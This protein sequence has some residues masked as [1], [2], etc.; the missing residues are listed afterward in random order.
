MGI[1]NKYDKLNHIETNPRNIKIDFDEFP[2]VQIKVKEIYNCEI[3]GT[4]SKGKGNFHGNIVMSSLVKF[5]ADEADLNKVDWKDSNLRKCS[6][7][8]TSFDLGAV[9]NCNFSECSFTE[10]HFDNMSITGAT[11]YDTEFVNC[12][13]T[14]MVIESCQF[15][16]CS[17]KNCKTSN[18]VFEHCLL[19]DCIFVNTDIQ[20]QTILENFG[21]E[22]GQLNNCNV[23]SASTDEN[24]EFLSYHAILS[25]CDKD[26]SIHNFFK[27]KLEYFLNPK[28]TLNG[29]ILF[30]NI[31]RIGEW[32]PLCKV[33]TTFINMFKLF[34]DF[35]I[36]LFENNRTPIFTIYKLKEL[37]GWLSS[38]ELIKNNFELYP[39]IIGFDLGL[40][41]IISQTL[42]IIKEKSETLEGKISLLVEGPL[43][44]NFYYSILTKG[45]KGNFQITKLI[46]QNSPNILEIT[47]IS[48]VIIQFVALFVVTR[49]KAEFSKQKGKKKTKKKDITKSHKKPA[50]P[51][52][53]IKFGDKHNED[54]ILQLY[55]S[56][57]LNYQVNY[58]E[59]ISEDIGK[60][61]KVIID[62]Y[63][64]VS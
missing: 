35:F 40:S 37:T 1:I 6:F 51:Y 63:D 4:F 12:D 2:K 28:I 60:I 59:F 5:R 26:N 62:I 52:Q 29:S 54:D 49:V 39:T 30:D 42:L 10:C 17:F 64:T 32:L 36:I 61:R 22:K 21:L 14:H 27:F 46:K 55:F 8:T 38:H 53:L 56:K 43:D 16:N 47:A 9:I 13:I 19:L 3:T 34:H 58:S 50:N 25:I 23:R 15:F 18:K 31:F 44:K 48:S 41:R 11:F 33:Q 24:F 45:I 57:S 7:I 20:I